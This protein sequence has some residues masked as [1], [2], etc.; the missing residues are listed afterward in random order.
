MM[1][2][3]SGLPSEQFHYMVEDARRLFNLSMAHNDPMASKQE[4]Y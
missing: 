3:S 2:K 4:A 1:L